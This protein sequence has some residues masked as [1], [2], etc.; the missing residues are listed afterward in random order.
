MVTPIEDGSL[1]IRPRFVSAT[2][3]RDVR[4]SIVQAAS[5]GVSWLPSSAPSTT[6]YLVEWSSAP[7]FASCRA[8]SISSGGTR[9][10]YATAAANSQVVAASSIGAD[11]RIAYTIGSL[12]ANTKQY[13]RVSAYNGNYGSPILGQILT[14]STPATPE[15]AAVVSVAAGV[16]SVSPR[17]LPPYRPTSVTMQVS[18]VD[19]PTLLEVN[20]VQPTKDALGFTADNGGAAITHYRLSWWEASA[21]P[22][23]QSVT[24]YDVRMVDPTG[25][26][27]T[28][29]SAACMFRLGAEVQSLSLTTPS[30]G[31][32]R[33]VLSNSAFTQSVC[34]GCSLSFAFP[35]GN[36]G[37]ID[38][39]G[40]AT[41]LQSVLGTNTRF[42]VDKPNAG[43]V[44]EVAAASTLPTN[45]LP[46]W[47]VSAANGATTCPLGT[48]SYSVHVEPMTACIPAT[49][50]A[51][52]LASA[53]SVLV[54]N[55][56][57]AVSLDVEAGSINHFRITFTGSSA[58][59]ASGSSAA[60][61]ADVAQLEVVATDATGGCADVSGNV[62]TSTELNGACSS[63]ACHTQCRLQHLTLWALGL[64]FVPLRC[65]TTYRAL[66]ALRL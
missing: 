21:S 40:S 63:P 25:G 52:A 66:L 2:G 42:M 26:P 62:W 20:F 38:Y 11:G 37:T 58:T 33:L 53:V 5:L 64:H 41:N 6:K 24:S 51:A 10:D 3:P 22:N 17:A 31:S 1:S 48:G 55:D 8:G 30:T 35:A 4:V 36:S 56:G 32:F 29:S 60:H 44:F 13:V 65:A 50:N 57:V 9:T 23:A 12:P 15:D 14:V 34:A 45:K 18:S 39:T 19:Q 28:C 54:N 47:F 59:G 46:V 27:L 49:T 16:K 43:C 61:V 7:D